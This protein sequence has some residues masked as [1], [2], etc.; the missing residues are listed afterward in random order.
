MFGELGPRLRDDGW[1]S[2][3]PVA[4]PGKR[5]LIPGWEAYNRAPPTDREVDA[6]CTFYPNAGIGLA[7]GPD[8]LLGVDLDFLEP[9]V[10]ARVEAIVREALGQSDCLRI[11]RPPKRLL[12]YRAGPGLSVPGKAFGGYEIFSTTGQ[13]VLYGTHPDTGRPYYWPGKSPEDVSPSDL[14]VV[15]QAPLNGM[16]GALAPPGS[17]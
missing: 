3:R 6:W 7:Y 4:N 10:A 9:A 17:R 2:V 5:P 11:G 1:G 15:D 8:G 16:A 14:P 12:L 13:T